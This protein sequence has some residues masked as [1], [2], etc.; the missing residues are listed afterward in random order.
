VELLPKAPYVAKYTAQQFIVGFSFDYQTGIHSF[1]SDRK[2]CFQAMPNTLATVPIGCD[3][4]SESQIGGEY[5]KISYS[6]PSN[7]KLAFDWRVSNYV[8]VDAI[9]AAFVLRRMLFSRTR[10]CQ[11][12]YELPLQIID[13]CIQETLGETEKI[14][15][16]KRWMNSDRFKQFEEIVET[17][18]DTNM[19]LIG[20]AN[21][22]EISPAYFSR[23]FKRFVGQSP[24]QY[25]LNKRI[26][27][28]RQL[29]NQTHSDLSAIALDCGFASH[30]HMTECFR[31]K[32]GI[33][34]SLLRTV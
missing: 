9:K 21:E 15:S 19:T 22:L 3:V 26:S 17:N 33:T 1:A 27:R 24:H 30:A 12:D 31:V 5:L 10:K 25:I 14:E 29:L 7:S 28:A 16:P 23:E 4:F 6:N 2:Q 11:L 34:P 8:N 18:L 20:I 32:L 13:D